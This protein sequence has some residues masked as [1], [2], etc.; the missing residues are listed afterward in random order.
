MQPRL[1]I[2]MTKGEVNKMS[3]YNKVV[4][5]QR[6]ATLGVIALTVHPFFLIGI[7]LIIGK[8]HYG[9]NEE[10]LGENFRRLSDR[11]WEAI[12]GIESISFSNSS[13]IITHKGVFPEEDLVNSIKLL[14][15]PE[16][17]ANVRLQSLLDMEVE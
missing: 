4:L 17:E 11:L 16:L 2:V 12:P 9:F 6:P 1:L 10:D 8:G 14:V 7:H 15:R 5:F 13:I 3:D